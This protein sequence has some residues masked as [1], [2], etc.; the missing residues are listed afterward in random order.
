MNTLYDNQKSNM[1][2]ESGN[3]ILREHVDILVKKYI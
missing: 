1:K 2:K 3:K